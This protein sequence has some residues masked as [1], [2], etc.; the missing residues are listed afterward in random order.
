MIRCSVNSTR[1]STSVLGLAIPNGPAT[2]SRL[3]AGHDPYVLRG[4][5][6]TVT[7]SGFNREDPEVPFGV[8]LTYELVVYPPDRRVQTNPVPSPSFMHGVQGWQAGTGRTLTLTADASGAHPQVGA[9]TG[10]PGGF[11]T[12]TPPTVIG[13][14]TTPTS[15]VGSYT[16]TPAGTVADGDYLYLVHHQVAGTPRPVV[17]GFTPMFQTTVGTV[18]VSVW[19]RKRQAGDS[20]YVITCTGV[21]LGILCWV[22]GAGDPYPHIVGPAG[23]GQQLQELVAPPVPTVARPSLLLIAAAV[24]LSATVAA[25]TDGLLGATTVAT[26]DT[27]TRRT[28]LGSMPITDAGA[29]PAL[30]IEFPTPALAA[31]AVQIIIQA[32]APMTN[33]IIATTPA[34]AVPASGVPHLMSG[35]FKFRTPDLWLWQDVRNQ[36]TWQHLKDTKANWAA[37]LS[38]ASNAPSGY[39]RFYVDIV[40]TPIPVG[41]TVPGTTGQW[42]AYVMNAVAA[43]IPDTTVVAAMNVIKTGVTPGFDVPSSVLA[44]D[45]NLL[46]QLLLDLHTTPGRAATVLSNS[47]LGDPALSIAVQAANRLGMV[48]TAPDSIATVATTPVYVPPVQVIVADAPKTNTWVD[49]SFFFTLGRDLPADAIIRFSHGTNL[50]EFAVTWSLDRVGVVLGADRAAHDTLTYM[51]GDTPVPG[52]PAS[53][54]LPGG[55]WS[56][57]SQDSTITW[58]GTPGASASVFMGP[59]K[60]KASTT[61]QVDVPADVTVCSPIYLNDPITPARGQWYS[62]LTVSDLTYKARRAMFDVI[63]RGPQIAVSQTRGWASGSFTLLTRT[64][65]ERAAALQTLQT[66][67]ILLYRNPDPAYPEDAWYISIGDVV[68][69]RLAGGDQ[70][71]DERQWQVPFDQVERP[72]GLIEQSFGRTW[73]DVLHTWTNWAGVRRDNATWLDLLYPAN[74]FIPS[75]PTIGGPVYPGPNTYPDPALYPSGA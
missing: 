47:V 9:V 65:A 56:D 4:G 45:R 37:V 44:S 33:R 27:P 17:A 15:N 16:I 48:L 20:G 58:T 13:S 67:R 19:R 14:V 10:N 61:C 70:R 41:G 64:R 63:G 18:D 74:G 6:F 57:V 5:Q 54:L 24:E 50:R 26:C 52:D 55:G 30:P 32:D 68:E 66:G 72:V 60:V 53:N 7:N 43:P 34:G 8:P 40:G 36:G 29:A 12:V 39:L 38:S 71:R 23:Q 11:A 42:A 3:V 51:D 73:Q 25:G 28:I 62:L 59:S 35:R 22:R 69:Q 1:G 21:A 49:F 2:L 46:L 31:A 75:S